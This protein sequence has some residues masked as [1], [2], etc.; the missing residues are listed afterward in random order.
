MF[1]CRK[2][3]LI[4]GVFLSF[5]LYYYWF[6][7]HLAYPYIHHSRSTENLRKKIK[8]PNLCK[9][10]NIIKYSNCNF[11]NSQ[12]VMS[13]RLMKETLTRSVPLE[14]NNQLSTDED[15]CRR[16]QASVWEASATPWQKKLE[17]NSAEK[18]RKNSSIL[19]TLFH[20]PHWHCLAPRGN[21]L[22]RKSF[23]HWFEQAASP[24]FWDTMQRVETCKS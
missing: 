1:T 2:L 9:I 3:I 17:N 5:Y 20:A 24:A 12:G 6:Q 21:S 15:S 8:M 23:L 4:L 22:A 7:S 19:P 14:I 16:A 13:P 18:G 10:C 11:W